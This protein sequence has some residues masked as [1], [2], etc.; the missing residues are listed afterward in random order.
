MKRSSS[1]PDLYIVYRL[2][3]ILKEHGP[4]SKTSLALYAKLNYQ[5]AV[6]Y[7]QHL[8]DAG[9]V[10]LEKEVALTRK[11]Y[12]TLE[13]LEEVLKNLGVTHRDNQK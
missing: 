4:L 10:E 13:K 1:K 5:R 11:G 2:L 9:L 3:K 12:E 6:A 8:S 7:L